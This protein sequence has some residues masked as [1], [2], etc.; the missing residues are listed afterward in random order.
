MENFMKGNHSERV[1][2]AILQQLSP[3][4]INIGADDFSARHPR[5]NG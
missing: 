1:H 4:Y 3:R 2:R 5:E